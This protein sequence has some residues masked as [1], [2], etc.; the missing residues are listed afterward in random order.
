M[1]GLWRRELGA[2]GQS[3]PPPAESV[4]VG[5]LG[6]SAGKSARSAMSWVARAAELEP[7]GAMPL[8]PVPWMVAVRFARVRLSQQHRQ[9]R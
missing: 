6:G 3:G 7:I 9:A 5:Q 1:G 8:P 2:V 4:G